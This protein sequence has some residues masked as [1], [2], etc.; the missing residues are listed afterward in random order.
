[1]LGVAQSVLRQ[2]TAECPE[3]SSRKE[4]KLFS[5]HW[6]KTDSGVHLACYPMDVQNSAFGGKAAAALSWLLISI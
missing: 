5:I 1:M 6:V 2:A 3:F 4:Q